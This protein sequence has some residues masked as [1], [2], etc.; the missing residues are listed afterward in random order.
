[1]PKA[2]SRRAIQ[3][4]LH[5]QKYRRRTFA[6]ILGL[7]KVECKVGSKVKF[8]RKVSQDVN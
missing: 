3:R 8:L 6:K 4:E 5:R 7:L 1:M 2:V